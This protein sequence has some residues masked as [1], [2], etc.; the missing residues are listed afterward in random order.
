MVERSCVYAPQCSKVDAW[1]KLFERKAGLKVK[2]LE[3]YDRM[4]DD[5]QQGRQKYGPRCANHP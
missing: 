2:A 3:R 4:R 1:I 5:G